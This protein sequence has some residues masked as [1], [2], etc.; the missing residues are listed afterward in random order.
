MVGAINRKRQNQTF[1]SYIAG[2]GGKNRI[3][4]SVGR[5][6]EGAVPLLYRSGTK[7]GAVCGQNE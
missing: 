2:G 3:D 1:I 6:R 4:F 5:D 7:G